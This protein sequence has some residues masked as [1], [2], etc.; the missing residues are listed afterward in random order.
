MELTQAFEQLQARCMETPAEWGV[1]DCTALCRSWAQEQF[2]AVFDLPEY[3]SREEAHALI[4]EAGSLAAL[5]ARHIG[6]PDDGEAVRGSVGII[7]M[8]KFG[9]VG[10]ICAGNGYWFWRS[11]DGYRWVTPLPRQIVAH[12]T[13]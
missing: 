7:D 5:W 1:D 3:H 13:F 10:M 8:G 2:G 12:W 4:Q 11:D 6:A 9:Q